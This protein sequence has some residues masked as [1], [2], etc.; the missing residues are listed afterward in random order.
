[1]HKQLLVMDH[2]DNSYTTNYRLAFRIDDYRQTETCNRYI[3][4]RYLNYTL[5]Y[6]I[7]Y[8]VDFGCFEPVG[9]WCWRNTAKYFVILFSPFFYSIE[10]EVWLRLV[11]TKILHR[12]CFI[13]TE[14]QLRL[15]Q[16]RSILF[17]RSRLSETLLPFF[18]SALPLSGL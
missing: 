15:H 13:C 14:H 17:Y 16:C 1:M 2:Y 10:R 4:L 6:T 18:F 5:R 12:I 8:T 9:V 11:K 3:S 7:C